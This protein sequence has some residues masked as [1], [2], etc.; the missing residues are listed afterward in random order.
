MPVI[1]RTIT[2]ILALFLLLIAPACTN[3][4]PLESSSATTRAALI[5][6]KGHYTTKDDV[7]AYLHYYHH[8]PSNFITKK[9]AQKLGWKGGGLDEYLYEGCI[10]GDVFGNYEGRLPKKKSGH[11]HECDID[12]MHQKKRGTKRLIYS[13]DGYIYYTK[14]H[15]ET[16]DLLYGGT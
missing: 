11:Y 8:L 9:Q 15:Y 12:T 13:Q 14:D 4:L 3:D 1:K 7:A 10:G 16:F 5:D 6:E 2:M